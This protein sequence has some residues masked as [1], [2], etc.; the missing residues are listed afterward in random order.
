MRAV[1]ETRL[2]AAEKLRRDSEHEK[3]AK[4]GFARRALMEQEALMEKVVQESNKL[5]EEAQENNKVNT[6]LFQISKRKVLLLMKSCYFSLFSC[7]NFSWIV[8]A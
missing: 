4:E 6:S 2:A 7:V 1:L 3:H 5:Q 8:A